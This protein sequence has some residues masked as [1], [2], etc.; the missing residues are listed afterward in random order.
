MAYLQA[1]ASSEVEICW[2][3]SCVCSKP[4]QFCATERLI[5]SG[6]NEIDDDIS[7]DQ[8]ILSDTNE[9]VG[10]NSMMRDILVRNF[11]MQGTENRQRKHRS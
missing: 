7:V 5:A 9:R 8:Y 2:E 1:S 10:G 6:F 3:G 11:F 4:L